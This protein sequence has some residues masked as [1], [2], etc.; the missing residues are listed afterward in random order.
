MALDDADDPTGLGRVP[1]LYAHPPERDNEP[2]LVVHQHTPDAVLLV[3]LA[4]AE[5]ELGVHARTVVRCAQRAA[6]QGETR[7]GNRKVPLEK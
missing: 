1:L 5:D 2:V 7:V 6:A 4:E 3:L